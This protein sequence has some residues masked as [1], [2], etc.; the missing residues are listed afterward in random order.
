MIHYAKQNK[1]LKRARAT[2]ICLRIKS[3]PRK[4]SAGD[5]LPV[6]MMTGQGELKRAKIKGDVTE[7][8]KLCYNK[9]RRDRER[10]IVR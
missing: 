8:R 5:D 3:K 10:P 9:H 6:L 1:L 7:L 4:G 2:W